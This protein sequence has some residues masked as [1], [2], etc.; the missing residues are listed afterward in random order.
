MVVAARAG[1]EN[2][3][4]AFLY[5]NAVC[6]PREVTYST[7]R[8]DPQGPGSLSA[9]VKQTLRS[10]LAWVKEAAGDTSGDL[11][12]IVQSALELFE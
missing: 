10:T 3:L 4:R 2:V 5:T 6:E 9:D 1:M 8:G 12:E 11:G 7:V